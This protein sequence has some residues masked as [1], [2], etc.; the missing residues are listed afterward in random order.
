MFASSEGRNGKLIVE[1]VHLWQPLNAYLYQAKIIFGDD[2]YVI[3]YGVRTVKVEGSKFL[4]NGNPFYFK[5]YGKHEDTFPAGRGLNIPMNV[6]D[7][8]LLKWQGANSFRT[9]H[10]PL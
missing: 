7:I 3:P 8:S 1:Q 6:K 4:I 9:S 10:Y 2:I 5:G